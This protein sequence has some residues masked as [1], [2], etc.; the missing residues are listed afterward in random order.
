MFVGRYDQ[1]NVNAHLMYLVSPRYTLTHLSQSQYFQYKAH[2]TLL[3]CLRVQAPKKS[4]PALR[5]YFGSW[6]Q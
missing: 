2:V 4:P 6:P 3:L 1:L 5:I